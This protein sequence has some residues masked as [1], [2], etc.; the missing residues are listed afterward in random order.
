MATLEQVPRHT[1]ATSAANETGERYAKEG[2]AFQKGQ[3]C[4]IIRLPVS[5][6]QHEPPDPHDLHE[7][8]R[9]SPAVEIFLN[10][11]PH[12]SADL[13]HCD[14]RQQHAL[15][16]QCDRQ[17]LNVVFPRRPY[18]FER[19]QHPGARN[20]RRLDKTLHESRS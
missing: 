3:V 19:L 10:P 8:R 1:F 13:M 2:G 15:L 11:S 12:R 4:T 9:C 14:I 5:G 6:I 18:L 16:H 7:L 20:F 17:W